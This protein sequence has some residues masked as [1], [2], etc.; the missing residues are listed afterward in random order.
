[1]TTLSKKLT[2]PSYNHIA[3]GIILILHIVGLYQ[4][5]INDRVSLMESSH[6]I[7]LISSLLC[8]VPEFRKSKLI[9]IPYLIV[10]LIGLFA[11]IIGVNTGLLFGEYSYSDSLG[12]KLLDTP[13][14]IGMLWLTL[15]VGIQ[16]WL[17]MSPLKKWPIFILGALIMT[18]FD[19][20]LEPVAIHFNLWQW[21][22]VGVPWFN[23][24]CWFIIALVMQPII[25]R[26]TNTRSL[27]RHLFL[28]NVFFFTCLFFSI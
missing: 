20:L 19:V 16:S 7:I 26:Y 18:L 14:I 13:I 15:S 3:M 23:Y 8:L 24:L 10:F 6:I 1:M 21:E 22:G 17:K 12:L 11:E 27:F 2:I 25:F 4:I 9:T 28:V 5:I